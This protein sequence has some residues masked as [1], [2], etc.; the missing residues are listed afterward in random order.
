MRA[1]DAGPF[2]E[3][4]G[5]WDDDPA[6]LETECATSCARTIRSDSRVA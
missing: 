1:A 6:E 2:W 3:I 5:D 4:Y